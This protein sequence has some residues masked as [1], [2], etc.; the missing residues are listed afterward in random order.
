MPCCGGVCVAVCV[1]VRV[2]ERVAVRVAERVAV[3]VAVHV[4]VCVAVAR[5]TPV[6]CRIYSMPCCMLQEPC[7]DTDNVYTCIMRV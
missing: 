6:G 4:A 2:A 5:V 3:R 7:L 1:A